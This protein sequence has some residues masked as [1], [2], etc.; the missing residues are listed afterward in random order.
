M[1]RQ[2]DAEKQSRVKYQE[3][4]YATMNAIDS[5]LGL[6]V[7]RGEGTTVDSFKAN[8]QRM[9]DEIKR[10][11]FDWANAEVESADVGLLLKQAHAA[12]CS[13]QCPS[14]WPTNEP[15]PHCD[16]CRR[17]TAALGTR[18]ERTNDANG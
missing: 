7:R 8:L 17:I 9:L 5:F 14:V 1:Q 4:A 13:L 2:Y 3:L 6:N 11:L 12:V 10:I 16:L 15:R 18:E